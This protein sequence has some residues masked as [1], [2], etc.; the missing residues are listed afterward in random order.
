M[1]DGPMLITLNNTILPR[2]SQ[3]TFYILQAQNVSLQYNT[4][5]NCGA[6]KQGGLFDLQ[7][8]TFY[9]LESLYQNIGADWGGVIN[10]ESCKINIKGSRFLKNRAGSAGVISLRTESYMMASKVFF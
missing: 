4:L 2:V 7:Q 9:D 5:Q 1:S 10:C 3:N 6:N 8:T